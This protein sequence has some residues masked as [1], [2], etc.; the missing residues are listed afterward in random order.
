[1]Y[2]NDGPGEGCFFTAALLA[3]IGLI[4]LV[5]GVVYGILWIINHF[6]Y[7]P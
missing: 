4:A 5:I 1:M 2:G 3:V 6:Q 7:V